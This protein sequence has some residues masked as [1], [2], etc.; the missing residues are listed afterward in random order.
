MALPENELRQIRGKD[1][2]YVFQDPVSSLNPVISIGDQISEAFL[3]HFSASRAEAAKRAKDFLAAVKIKDVDRVF[4]SF[5]H[6]LSGGM[7]QRAMIA[8]VLIGNPKLLIA[9]EPTTALDVSVEAE[10]LRLLLE[11]QKEKTLSL[12]FITH[13]LGLAAAHAETIF[14]MQKGCVVEHLKKQNGRFELKEN[15]TKKLFHAGLYASQPKSFI[16]V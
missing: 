5:P 8:M 7:N 2:G 6:E 3:A 1:I 16:N 15:Y 10:I 9:D 12:L 4:H 14:V 11:V 13:N